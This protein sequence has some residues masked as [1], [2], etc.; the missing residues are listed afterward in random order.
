M[1][2]S[3]K[4]LTIASVIP[5]LVGCGQ[6]RSPKFAKNGYKVDFN[7]FNN[8]M[9]EMLNTTVFADS[10]GIPSAKYANT[11]KSHRKGEAKRGGK[12]LEAA[13]Q[14]EKSTKEYL[15]DS[16]N[17][18]VLKKDNTSIKS[19]Q[20]GKNVSEI[21]RSKNK[22]EFYFQRY[23]SEDKTY[24]I[25]ADFKYKRFYKNTTVSNPEDIPGL[26]ED[27]FL[28]IISGSIFY[29]LEYILDE[30]EDHADEAEKAKYTFY[31]NENNFTIEYETSIDGESKDSEDKVYAHYNI[32]LTKK[33]QIT[34]N[35]TKLAY[36]YYLTRNETNSYVSE[37]NSYAGG[38]VITLES[39]ESYDQTLEKNDNSITP[40]SLS[41][42]AKYGTNW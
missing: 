32:K 30:Y 15:Y 8:Q 10:G 41:G 39:S 21:E 20:Y 35:H 29:G 26:I 9:S 33:I 18:V 28:D 19:G 6:V 40:I 24:I 1:K 12:R 37:H 34:I 3:I 7:T 31:R 2:R 14:N 27:V 23:D 4:L 42:F 25:A 17:Y 5:L 11:Y 16:N 36:K 38:D 22:S 13:F